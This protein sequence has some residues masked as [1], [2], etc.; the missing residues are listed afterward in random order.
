MNSVPKKKRHTPALSRW[1]LLALLVLALTGVGLWY[2]SLESQPVS[3][4]PPRTDVYEEI[5][6]YEPADI[7]RLTVTQRD[8]SAWT[9][10]QDEHGSV[11]LAGAEEWPLDAALVNSIL[12]VASVVSYENVVTD[13][14]NEYINRLADFGLDKPRLIVDV[15]YADGTNAVLRIGDAA[16]GTDIARAY[17]LIDGRDGLYM[18]DK[19]SVDALNIDQELL[20]SVTQPVIHK[21][22]IDQITLLDASGN[23]YGAWELTG[24]ITDVDAAAQWMMTEPA[25]YPAD[26]DALHDL[27]DSLSNLRLGAYV[28]QATPENRTAYGFNAPRFVIR[29]HQAAGTTNDINENGEIIFVDW[30]ASDFTME[31]GAARNDYVDYVLVDGAIYTASHFT[32]DVFMRMDVMNTVSRYPVMIA[33]ATL[34]EMII[35]TDGRRDVYKLSRAPLL[36]QDNRIETDEDGN[37]VYETTVT[38]NG[39]PVPYSA[40][41]S[42]YIRMET[43]RISGLLPSG[44]TASEP[45]HTTFTLRSTSGLT[46]TIALSPFDALH[47]AVIVNDCALFYLIRGGME[48]MLNVS[49]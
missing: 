11:T 30:P 46:Q 6:R 15:T 20:H 4:T 23:V 13:D 41:E 19:G 10:L 38:C 28:A 45:P 39:S 34:D 37:A 14:P 40:F 31:I 22:R 48:F 36:G 44:W 7:R 17:M 8:G 25:R 47:D 33:A 29:V 18:L 27:R 24:S 42:A 3:E 5:H 49:E 2:G 16:T 43:V 21:A 26:V 12:M 32:L 9:L 35:E 1:A